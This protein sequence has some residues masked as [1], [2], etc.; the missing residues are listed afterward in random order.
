MTDMMGIVMADNS[1][2]SLNELTKLRSVTAIPF[3][4]RYRLIDFILSNMVN[5]GIINVGVATNINYSSLMDH[6]GSGAPWDLNRKIYGLFILPPH[7][8]GGMGSVRAGNI[9]Q[10]YGILTFLRRSRQKYVLLASGRIVCN[11]TFDGA[12]EA[13]IK[14]DADITVIYHDKGEADTQLSRG[15][16]YEIDNGGRVAGIE[17]EPH[18]PKSTYESMDMYIMDRVKLIEM[19][20]E[21]YSKGSHDLIRDILLEQMKDLKI[22][23]YE[24]KGFVGKI[25]SIE[26]Y[27]KNSIKMLDDDV[28]RELF[29]SENRIYTKVKD[30]VPTQYGETAT[31]KDALIADGCIIEGCVENSIISRGVHIAK[32]AVVKNSI[33]MQN[34]VIEENCELENAIIDK[35]C[36]IREQKRLIGHPEHPAIL[37]KRTLL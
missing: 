30:Q 12:L 34:S 10:L 20:D 15:V 16:V 19:I 29:H 22:Y 23:G 33:V 18:F 27:Y 7:V 36:T 35:E 5:S 25:D 6:I 2:L 11:M 9:D 13:H 1:E 21:A 26:S 4:G 32:G 28:R 17:V 8:K 14:N 37:P 24:Y 3:G 31:I